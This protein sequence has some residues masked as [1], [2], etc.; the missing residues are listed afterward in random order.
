MKRIS[1]IDVDGHIQEREEDV[2]KYLE[3]PWNRRKTPLKPGDQPWDLTLFG[4]REMH[5]T[6]HG[7]SS[8]QQVQRWHEIMDEHGVEFV[9]GFPSG[10]GGVVKTQQV[11]FQIA[12]ARAVNNH[13][14]NDYNRPSKR[15]SVVG[16]LPLRSPQAAVEEMERAVTELGMKGFEI[17]TTGLPAPL[18]DTY[19]DPIYTVAERL[20]VV[21]GIHG[22]RAYSEELGTS[23]FRTF[24]EVHAYAFPAGLMLQFTSIV[25]QGVPVRF[26]KLK[27]ALLEAGATWV[28]YYLD[29][30]DEHWEIRG[31]YELPL[32]KKNPSDL[33]RE[34][35]IYFSLEAGESLLPAAVKHVGAEH[36]LFASDVPHWDNEFPE[37]LEHL[38]NHPDLSEDAK[39]KILYKNAKQLF[40]L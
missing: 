21:L 14:T 4:T 5:A 34:S 28:P 26:P 39:E 7:Y 22:T 33:V 37:N 3:A 2:R 16:V 40:N 11:E 20:G 30:L 8:S 13:L 23:G 36:F 38:R 18:G 6:W 1:A 25:L 32:L 9:I 29:R 15:L 27:M 31:E 17:I 35:Q 10:F 12:V 19:Y 24:S